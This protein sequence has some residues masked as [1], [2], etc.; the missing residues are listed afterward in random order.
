MTEP[1]PYSDAELTLSAISVTFHR[2]RAV[3]QELTGPASWPQP[4]ADETEVEEY[5]DADLA[6]EV[7]GDEP[8]GPVAVADGGPP[9]TLDDDEEIDEADFPNPFV[10]DAN[11]SHYLDRATAHQGRAAGLLRAV[12][13]LAR[14]D[15]AHYNAAVVNA[16]HQL[17][18]RTRS[19]QRTITRLEAELARARRALAGL[20][21]AQDTAEGPRP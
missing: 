1:R 6:E 10:T 7:A 18:H 17:D 3:Q 4:E 9:L 2:A 19:Q 5:G 11:F 13:R 16:L 21:D 12:R 8:G 15:Q 14:G 20:D